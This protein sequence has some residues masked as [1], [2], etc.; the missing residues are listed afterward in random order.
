MNDYEYFHEKE[1]VELKSQTRL[2]RKSLHEFLISSGFKSEDD[3]YYIDRID[4][5]EPW[6]A[7]SF[8][9]VDVFLDDEP[10]YETEEDIK[11]TGGGT[12]DRLDTSYLLASLP[13]SYISEFCDKVFLLADKFELKVYH[14]N[15]EAD[16][17]KLA[18]TFYSYAK[19]LSEN[20]SE[21]GSEDLGILIQDTYPR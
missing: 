20:Y 3:F 1:T 21:P 11:E 10:V 18:E 13:Q 8:M 7:V 5:A 9:S 4:K 19:E 15:I 6:Q 2:S 12:W 16:K 17:S 14:R